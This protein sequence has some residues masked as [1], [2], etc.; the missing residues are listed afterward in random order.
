VKDA[1]TTLKLIKKLNEIKDTFEGMTYTEMK[2]HP[3]YNDAVKFLKASFSIKFYGEVRDV[4]I[5]E[6]QSKL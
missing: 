4:S 3:S 6:I 5:E 1:S 2:N